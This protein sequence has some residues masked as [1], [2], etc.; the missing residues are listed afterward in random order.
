MKRLLSFFLILCLLFSVL[1]VTATATSIAPDD[2][3]DL[4]QDIDSGK[5]VKI[6]IKGEISISQ[7]ALNLSGQEGYDLLLDGIDYSIRIPAKAA[8]S[9][10]APLQIPKNMT[11]DGNASSFGQKALRAQVENS[12]KMKIQNTLGSR[13]SR[14]L[15]SAKGGIVLLSE[16]DL[17]T[18]VFTST[19]LKGVPA[20]SIVEWELN[21]SCR[22]TASLLS[23][24]DPEGNQHTLL[25]LCGG[26]EKIRL[27]YG[28]TDR[29]TA[30]ALGEEEASLSTPSDSDLQLTPA[31]AT[32]RNLN[33]LE[34]R[35]GFYDRISDP[36]TI[37]ASSLEIE[38]RVSEKAELDNLIEPEEELVAPD[39]EQ[40]IAE[41]AQNNL[42]GQLTQLFQSQIN[43]MPE[44]CL[45]LLK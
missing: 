20:G 8:A 15:S 35:Q 27:I 30:I 18:Q 21:E 44:D 1:P 23:A 40:S 31:K 39:L 26:T 22:N 25:A 41:Y 16:P 32:T 17:E 11:A 7:K 2:I 42:L 24:F 33:K 9:A 19:R 4:I 45:F 36:L 29:I 38:F 14:W 43:T 5:T 10:A 34:L 3:E 28:K 12:K 6:K 13:A 37:S